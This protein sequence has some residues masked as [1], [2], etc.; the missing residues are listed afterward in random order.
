MKDL[1]GV[2]LKPRTVKTWWPE[3]KKV[4]VVTTYLAVG[5]PDLV[6]SI[7]G[8]PRGTVRNWR[9]EPWWQEMVHQIQQEADQELDTKLQKRID[10]ALDLVMDRLDHGD[11]K[12]DFKTGTLTRVPVSMKD[13]AKLST[14]FF[15]KRQLIRRQPAQQA[16]QEAAADI[17]KKLALDFAG[18]ARSNTAKVIEGEV[19]DVKPEEKKEEVPQD[20]KLEELHP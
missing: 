9:Q 12:Y 14:D 6:E 18:F 13:A 20:A 10:K 7:T 4:E 1:V 17:L 2:G 3:K 15:D 11:Y 19:I 16:S 8:V 5:K